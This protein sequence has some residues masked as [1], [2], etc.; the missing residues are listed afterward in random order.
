MKR[1]WLFLV[2][3]AVLA[4]PLSARKVGFGVAKDGEKTEDNAYGGFSAWLAYEPFEFKFGNPSLTLAM[5]MESDEDWDISIPSVTLAVNVDLFRT[6]HHPF[7]I[8]AHNRVAW[9]P[10][11]SLG[12]QARFDGDG[13]RPALYMIVSPFKFSQ[14][15]FWYE[16][17]SPFFTYA[18]EGW[19]WGVALLRFTWM[20]L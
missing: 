7:W 2:L 12:V 17:L 13:N 14:P 20:F 8:I 19:S 5:A 4:C 1:F 15:D 11:L 9:D 18:S 3:V 10:A 6:L 16:A